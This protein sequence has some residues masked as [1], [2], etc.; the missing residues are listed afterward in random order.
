MGEAMANAVVG[1]DGF[2]D[3]PTL[4]ELERRIAEMV[5]KDTAMFVPSG[6]MSNQMAIRLQTQPG[7]LVLCH[8]KSHIMCHEYGGAAANSGVTLSGFDCEDPM[9]EMATVEKALAL[10]DN[11]RDSPLGLVCLENTHNDCGGVALDQQRVLQLA[12][13]LQAHNVPMHLDGAR[14]FNAAVATGLSPAELAEPFATVNICLSKGLGA[15]VGSLLCMPQH[16]RQ[17]ARRIRRYLGGMMR[18]TGVLAAAALHALDAHLPDLVEDHRRAHWL[19]ER[20]QT[21]PHVTVIPPQS[22]LVWF[23]LE[24]GHWLLES[25]KADQFVANLQEQGVWITGDGQLF[26][27]VTH[28]D[29]SDEQIDT[30]WHQLRAHLV[31][32]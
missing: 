9:P 17:R 25:Q 22:N 26:R 19:A 21:C 23:R 3:D 12:D 6:T 16:F 8:L 14:L 11:G 2:G 32:D 28:R 7:D 27:A 31:R 1:D 29:I 13:L 4:A 18:Q 24:P 10:A 20:L 30:A 15:P 5:G